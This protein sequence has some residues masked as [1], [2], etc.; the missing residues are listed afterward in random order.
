MRKRQVFLTTEVELFAVLLAVVVEH[1]EVVLEPR[2]LRNVL[3]EGLPQQRECLGERQTD[4]GEGERSHRVHRC[5][6]RTELRE[7]EEPVR[8]VAGDSSR[9]TRLTAPLT[10]HQNH[11]VEELHFT[12]AHQV[13]LAGLALRAYTVLQERQLLGKCFGGQ[14]LRNLEY[15]LNP[16]LPRTARADVTA[17]MQRHPHLSCPRFAF[18][19]RYVEAPVVEVLCVR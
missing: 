4:E 3:L 17:E 15:V 14:L 19:T 16:G 6:Q 7:L 5:R 8:M 9:S 13:R 12:G 10:P 18:Q 1:L 11:L 2:R